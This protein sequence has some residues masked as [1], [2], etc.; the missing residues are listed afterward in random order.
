[1]ALAASVPGAVVTNAAPASFSATRL[2]GPDDEATVGLSLSNGRSAKMAPL[3]AVDGYH[4]RG[5]RQY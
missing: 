2:I 4:C 3:V 5:V 1:M